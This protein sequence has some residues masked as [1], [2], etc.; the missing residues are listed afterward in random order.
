MSN[1]FQLH[2]IFSEGV[3]LQRNQENPVWGTGP[4]GMQLTLE[5][6]GQQVQTVC[7][8]GKWQAMLPASEAG[9]PHILTISSEG[10]Q[11]A[12]VQ[13]VYFGD[14]WLAGGQSNMEWKVRDTSHAETDIAEANFPLIRHFEVPRLE[15]EDSS[16]ATPMNATWKKATSENVPDFSGVAYH[17]AQ[18]IQASE[19][20]PIG[21]I[22][23]YWGGTSASSWVRPPLTSNQSCRCI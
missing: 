2:A 1:R 20:V 3:I 13:D 14:V 17:F 8:E 19:G 9:G 10:Q 18:H 6:Q 15:W 5:C 22:G 23:C 11:L 7:A 21:I 16:E 4:D 12:T